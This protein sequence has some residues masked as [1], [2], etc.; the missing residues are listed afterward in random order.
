MPIRVLVVVALLCSCDRGP[1]PKSQPIPPQSTEVASYEYPPQFWKT[2][3]NGHTEVSTYDLSLRRNKE[4]VKGTAVAIFT[5]EDFSN[6]SRFVVSGTGADVFPVMRMNLIK[7]VGPDVQEMVSAFAALQSVNQLPAGTIAKLSHSRQSWAGHT[8]SQLLVHR[9]SATYSWRSDTK[10]DGQSIV[11][12]NP[13]DAAFEDALPL[14]ARRIAH[15]VLRL[16][17]TLPAG[18]VSSISKHPPTIDDV[19]L[20]MSQERRTTVVPA[21]SY[22]TH[23]FRVKWKD[24]RTQTWEVET[25]S[26]HRIIRWQASDGETAELLSEKRPD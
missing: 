1:E 4:T 2:W 9:R 18:L 7:Q 17:Q 13:D 26:P 12:V 5:I 14:C 23:A 10:A 6:S 15:P 19:V 21:G 11:K 3:G 24:G 25:E 8:W 20:T 16:G 22:R